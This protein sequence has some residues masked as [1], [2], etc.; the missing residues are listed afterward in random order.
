MFNGY[1]QGIIVTRVG[2]QGILFGVNNVDPCHSYGVSRKTHGYDFCCEDL[3]CISSSCDPREA[4]FRDTCD[5][6]VGFV[7]SDLV[8]HLHK[9]GLDGWR[10]MCDPG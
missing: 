4:P 5:N 7:T 9:R 8:S 3:I 2:S 1:E 6:G 10:E